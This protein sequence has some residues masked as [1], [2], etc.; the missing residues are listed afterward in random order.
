[1]DLLDKKIKYLSLLIIV[2][3]LGLGGSSVYNAVID[4]VT[5]IITDPGNM[6]LDI[7]SMESIKHEYLW[8]KAYGGYT[9]KTEI[10][11]TGSN[12]VAIVRCNAYTIDNTIVTYIEET[13][14]FERNEA[15]KLEFIFKPSELPQDQ[16]YKFNITI[17]KTIVES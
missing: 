6:K 9:I 14:R 17:E 11:N 5:D 1:M 12:G 4:H 3:I 7:L 13:P 15:K 2:S 16:E 10:I 8:G